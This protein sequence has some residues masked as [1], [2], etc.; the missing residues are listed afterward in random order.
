VQRCVRLFEEAGAQGIHIED[1]VYPKRMDYHQGKHF[2]ITADEM[3]RKLDIALKTRTRDDFLIIARC[4]AGRNEGETIQNA[5]DRANI[6]AKSGVD[7]IKVFSRNE[8]EMIEAPKLIDFP[9]WYVASEGLGRPIPTPSEAKAM[10]YAAISYPQ[11][12]LL[13]AFEGY[14][15]AL[16]NLMTTGRSQIPTEEAKRIANEIMDLISIDDLAKL[17]TQMLTGYEK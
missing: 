5:I 8:K 16:N 4:D 13:A 15:K 11:T 2:I 12:A 3:L 14:S 9:L 6:Y 17:E 1:Q 10:G 7:V